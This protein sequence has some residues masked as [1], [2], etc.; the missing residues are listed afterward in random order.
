MIAEPDPS[1]TSRRSKH[2]STSPSNAGIPAIQQSGPTGEAENP[3]I[4]DV[5]DEFYDKYPMKARAFLVHDDGS[6]WDEAAGAY[7]PRE[8]DVDLREE[9]IEVTDGGDAIPVTWGAALRRFLEWL[10]ACEGTR[11]RF[12]NADGETFEKELLNSYDAEYL[13]VYYARLMA[14]HREVAGGERPTGEWTAG[15][16]E[17]PHTA[18][19]SLTS[20]GTYEDNTP[21]GPVDHQRERR[22][23]WGPTYKRLYDRMEALV[24]EGRIDAWTYVVIEEHHPGGGYGL[25][26]GLGH[27]HLV[28]FADGELRPE[29]LEPVVDA[30]V[31]NCPGATAE[32]HENTVKTRRLDGGN[33]ADPDVMNSAGGYLVKYLYPDGGGHPLE[34]SVEQLAHQAVK[35]VTYTRRVRKADAVGE[36]IRADRCRQRNDRGDQELGHGEDVRRRERPR[37][38]EAEHVCV[39]CGSPWGIDQASTLTAKRLEGAGGAA[40]VDENPGVTSGESQDGGPSLIKG[41][42]VDDMNTAGGWELEAVLIP[43]DDEPDGVREARPTTGSSVEMVSVLGI[44]Q[45]L[46]NNSERMDA[47]LEPRRARDRRGDEPPEPELPEP[48]GW[49]RPPPAG[50]RGGSSYAVLLEPTQRERRALL[51]Q[52]A[53]DLEGAAGADVDEVLDELQDRGVDAAKADHAVRRLLER[54]ELY[55]PAS[56]RLRMA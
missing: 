33:A 31:E 13:E 9:A 44:D 34:R 25:N 32:A 11:G 10:E 19:L 24:D 4:D 28:V 43:D 16:Y 42:D 23:A 36:A 45:Y 3:S 35:W 46:L 52:V 55:E 40:D 38:G 27:G 12:K 29:D 5:V 53:R 18:L 8:V 22:E 26:A 41:D 49:D 48:G 37:T 56:G 51:R 1:N 47:V 30:W 54:G 7:D 6:P 2:K 17:D 21:R 39:A 50:E 20:S 14:L 15:E